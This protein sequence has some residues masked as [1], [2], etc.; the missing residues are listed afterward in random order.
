[1]K[2]AILDTSILGTFW[3]H[4]GLTKKSA[5]DVRNAAK[6]LIKSRDTN[7]IVTPVYLECVAGARTGNELQ[8][9][10]AFLAEFNVVDAWHVSDDD[11]EAARSFAERI[12]HDGKPRHMGDCLIRAIANRISYE[13]SYIDNRFER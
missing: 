8:L 12:P 4:Q 2:K 9:M 13:V 7:A 6:Q 10:R 1:M 11:W 5:A 3:K